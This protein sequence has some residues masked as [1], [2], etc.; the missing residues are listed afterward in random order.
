MSNIICRL[1]PFKAQPVVFLV[2][3]FST[4]Y[5]EIL[6]WTGGNKPTPANLEYYRTTLPLSEDD[7]AL[8][9][10]RYKQAT[11][12]NEVVIRRRLPRLRRQ[13]PSIFSGTANAS[14]APQGNEQNGSRV[15]PGE[16]DFKAAM[17]ALQAEMADKVEA[18][19]R[20]WKSQQAKQKK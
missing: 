20:A 2:D 7:E 4:A 13:V 3:S 12:D 1:D 6:A 10:E 9:A 17:A 19:N 8:I 18:L 15:G 5:K 16:V 14:V 11:G